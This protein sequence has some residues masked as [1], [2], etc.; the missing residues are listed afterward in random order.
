M[1]ATWKRVCVWVPPEAQS[2]NY[3][4]SNITGVAR[5]L[6]EHQ[7]YRAL[8]VP[9]KGKALWSKKPTE[10]IGPLTSSGLLVQSG[11]L[12]IRTYIDRYIF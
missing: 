10:N 4:A 2:V 6:R 7:I 5:R 9:R 3:A 11:I 8:P 12:N 1:C